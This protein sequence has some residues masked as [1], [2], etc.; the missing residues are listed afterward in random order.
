[1]LIL[2]RVPPNPNI[3]SWAT[4][5]ATTKSM[6]TSNGCAGNA[7]PTRT[8]SLSCGSFNA[9]LSAKKTEWFWPTVGAAL[10]SKHHW[11][12]IARDACDTVIA[13]DLTVQ[14]R[15]PEAPIRVALGDVR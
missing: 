14:R 12:V 1:M 11:L 13:L 6:K 8:R 3:A 4:T 9:R 7:R 15:D 2:R 10:A 5:R